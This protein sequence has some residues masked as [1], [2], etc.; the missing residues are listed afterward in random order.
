MEAVEKALQS[1]VA[2]H[3]VIIDQAKEV[4][5]QTFGSIVAGVR[6]KSTAS[7]SKMQL[8][9]RACPRVSNCS[10]GASVSRCLHAQ[11]LK[12]KPRSYAES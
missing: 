8:E 9:N 2:E 4:A 7:P 10:K 6:G 5:R 11:R 1:I 3:N 12:S